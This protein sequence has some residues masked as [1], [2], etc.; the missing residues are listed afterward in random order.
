M[1]RKVFFRTTSEHGLT[2]GGKVDA[3][4]L[5]DY[6]NEKIVECNERID[7]AGHNGTSN[8]YAVG[9]LAL[10]QALK[11]ELYGKVYNT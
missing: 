3:K 1:S 2:P 8:N 7:E 6:L 10:L 5:L 4:N 11:E 9:A